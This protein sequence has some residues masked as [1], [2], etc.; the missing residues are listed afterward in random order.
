[1]G[2]FQL[3]SSRGAEDDM[4]R[5]SRKQP[6]S[7]KIDARTSELKA[8]MANAEAFAEVYGSLNS[9]ATLLTAEA[10]EIAH[11]I[12][13]MRAKTKKQALASIGQQRLRLTHAKAKGASA[14]KT[15]TW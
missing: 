7:A 2:I 1:M 13:G 5:N 14:Q 10:I 9:D 8:S 3:W 6:D 4:A 11:R 15:K 12:T